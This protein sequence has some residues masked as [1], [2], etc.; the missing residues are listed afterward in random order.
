[1]GMK[2]AKE[3]KFAAA[4]AAAAAAAG[5]TQIQFKR[6]QLFLFSALCTTPF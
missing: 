3:E 6:H 4:A 5:A 1:M 2:P